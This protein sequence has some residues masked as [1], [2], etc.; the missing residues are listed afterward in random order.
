MKKIFFE[1][2]KK[3]CGRTNV[4]TIFRGNQLGFGFRTLERGEAEN[5]LG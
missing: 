1:K 5:V 3:S 2:K 4:K